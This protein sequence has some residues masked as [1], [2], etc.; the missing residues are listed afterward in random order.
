MYAIRSYYAYMIIGGEA[1]GIMTQAF[2]G[3]VMAVA[4]I[5]IIIGFF[6]VTGG[7]GNVLEAVA[8]AGEVTGGGVTKKMSA[9]FLNAW[10]VLPGQVSM[11]YM[12]VPI[13]GTVGQPQVLT[14]M[15]A[16]KNPRD[17]VITSYS[18]HY[19]KLYELG[20]DADQERDDDHREREPDDQDLGARAHACPPCA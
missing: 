10:G 2:Q 4:G 16:L 8:K 13:L 12:L 6:V 20:P 19:T 9:D 3:L 11:V 15:Y 14:R 17:I 1:G 18:I 7:F 5:I